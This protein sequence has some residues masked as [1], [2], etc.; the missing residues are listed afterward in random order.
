MQFEIDSKIIVN[1]TFSTEPSTPTILETL[2]YCENI[3]A[4]LPTCKLVLGI[5]DTDSIFL[6][7]SLYDGAPLNVKIDHVDIDFSYNLN[8]SIFGSPT[9]NPARSTNEGYQ[10]T[11]YAVLYTYKYLTSITNNSYKGSVS[12]VLTTLAK[13]CG[14]RTA[15]VPTSDSQIWYSHGRTYHSLA[16]YLV[17]HCY[18]SDTSLPVLGITHPNTLVMKDIV[19]SLLKSPTH[20]LSY[21]AKVIYKDAEEV[22]KNEANEQNN[23][24]FV[25]Y[26]TKNVSGLLNN[27]STYGNTYLQDSVEDASGFES[28]GV[29]FTRRINNSEINK[30]TKKAVKGVTTNYFPI[31]T[32]NTYANFYKAEA[33]NKRIRNLYSNVFRALTVNEYTKIRLLDTVRLLIDTKFEDGKDSVYSGNYIVTAKTINISRNFFRE[34]ITLVNYGRSMDAADLL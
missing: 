31:N 13:E 1:V 25:T 27:T 11:L 34:A 24:I 4:G 5:R 21:L 22:K 12:S 14:L 8:L 19:G 18:M 3:Q 16:Q 28:S 20:T 29:T 2:E 32:G 6:S 15:I 9:M 33:K 23:Y 30:Q 7:K 26:T 17:N 10:V